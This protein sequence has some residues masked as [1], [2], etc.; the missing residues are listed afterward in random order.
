[1]KIL[2]III[3]LSLL[4]ACAELDDRVHVDMQSETLN[5]PITS[6]TFENGVE[7]SGFPGNYCTDV[8]CMEYGELDHSALTYTPFANG[9]TLTFKVD[10]FDE[11]NAISLRTI[12]NEGNVTHRELSYETIAP[13]IFLINEAFPD[14]ESQITLHISVDFLVEGYANYYYPI[15]LQ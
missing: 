11:I 13:N 12:N 1:M 8:L 7:I 9:S 5:R 4:S 6:L 3:A 14:D 10:F 2:T 15:E